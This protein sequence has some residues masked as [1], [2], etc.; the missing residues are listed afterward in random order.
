MDVRQRD[1]RRDRV[2]SS[3]VKHRAA[4]HDALRCQGCV[5]Q[6]AIGAIGDEADRLRAAHNACRGSVGRAEAEHEARIIRRS[7]GQVGKRAG[8]GR[9]RRAGSSAEP[10]IQAFGVASGG[11]C[12]G[13]RQSRSAER[14]AD[15]DVRQR[16]WRRDRVG[17]RVVIDSAGYRDRCSTG[18][19]RGPAERRGV[20]ESV[21]E[22]L[23]DG[24]C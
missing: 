22:I 12:V 3:E 2:G 17:G 10:G 7:T 4:H 14:A 23:I 6:T 13:D 20:G 8:V 5:R 1:W 16:D 24:T 19:G 21:G 11:S 9:Q 18:V 15:V